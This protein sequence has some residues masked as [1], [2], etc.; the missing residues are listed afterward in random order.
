MQMVVVLRVK[1]SIANVWAPNLS[2]NNIRNYLIR[3]VLR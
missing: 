2:S 1:A 3:L